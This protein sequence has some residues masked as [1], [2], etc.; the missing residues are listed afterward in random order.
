MPD[1]LQ[2]ADNCLMCGRCAEKC[3][4]DID[5][6]TLR[7]NSRDTMRNVPDEK[8]YGY[9]KGLDRSSGEGK[10]GYFAGCMTLL[11]PR[12]MSAMEK[13]FQAA[14]EEVWWADTRWGRLLRTPVETGR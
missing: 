13:V 5:L 10:V 1:R 6:N 2:V 11:T 9:F 4:V 12:T 3:P 7:L 14:G 8:R